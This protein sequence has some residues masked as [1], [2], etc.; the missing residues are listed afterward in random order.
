[1]SRLPPPVLFM[2]NANLDNISSEPSRRIRMWTLVPCLSKADK[3]F[4]ENLDDILIENK[5]KDKALSLTFQNKKGK[6]NRLP[7][8]FFSTS[9]K[10]DVW[11]T[12][13]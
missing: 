10:A 12:E 4:G 11:T 3:L 7:H 2:A 1:M 6:G 5:H 13:T 8:P 9:P